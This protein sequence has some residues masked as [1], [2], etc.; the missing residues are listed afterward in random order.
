MAEQQ[1]YHGVMEKIQEKSPSASQVVAVLALFPVG[2]TLL[3]L[4]G[5]T[6]TGTLIGLALLT[7]LFLLF[8]PVIVPAAILIA[9]SVAGFLA[10]GAFSLTAISSFSWLYKQVSGKGG[11][12]ME[13]I[14]HVKRRAQET[15]GQVGQR[16]REVG[17][18]AQQRAGGGRE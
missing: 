18:A 12:V 13:Q 17:Q 14:E 16:A 7:P 6:L 8:S 4:S 3:T 10:S 1:Q 15:A 11:P 9:L 5:V 2:G